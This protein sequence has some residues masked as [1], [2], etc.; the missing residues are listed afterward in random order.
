MLWELRVLT[1]FLNIFTQRPRVADHF[2]IEFDGDIPILLS[3]VL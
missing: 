2:P 1:N 3:D